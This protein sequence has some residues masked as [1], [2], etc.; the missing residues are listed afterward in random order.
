MLALLLALPATGWGATET[1][2][3]VSLAPVD[4]AYQVALGRLKESLQR[5]GFAGH[6]EE[7][8]LSP[9]AADGTRLPGAI[10]ARRPAVVVTLGSRATR[11]VAAQVKDLP[12]VFCMALNPVAEGIVP[13]LERPGGNVTGASL[14]LPAAVQ[15]EAIRAV[16]PA[17][18]RVGVLY[19][20]A[21][22]GPVVQEA[23]RAAREAGL[24]LVPRVVRTAAE[25]PRALEALGRQIDFLWAVAD[26]TVFFPAPDVILRF[27]LAN[28]IPF[29]GLS[30][31]FVRQGALM[32][33]VVDYGAVGDQCGAQVL[34]V[35]AG[36]APGE[37]P[38]TMPERVTLHLN[39]KTADTI[40]LKIPGRALRGAVLV[41]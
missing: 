38:V 19:N 29:M 17:A 22:T 13:A 35:L 39:L 1:V 37:L 8:E 40:G 15:F 12:V 26:S 25:V 33:L 5:G 31:G 41:R 7:L 14:D 34:Q 10:R 4:S 30:A 27:T 6:L 21:E 32:A 36:R 23:Q 11:S 20:P 9:D 16:V 3:A 2:L 24:T 18:R 28:G